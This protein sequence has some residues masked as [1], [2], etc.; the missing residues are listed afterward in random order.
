MAEPRN[1]RVS[2]SELDLS[3]LARAAGA[4][5]ICRRGQLSGPR[6]AGRGA[7]HHGFL[8]SLQLLCVRDLAVQVGFEPLQVADVFFVVLHGRLYTARILP[9][10][11]CIAQAR[12]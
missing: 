7:P 1:L 5:W 6:F 3:S 9:L 4:R 8:H 12:L 2:R 10:P 11:R